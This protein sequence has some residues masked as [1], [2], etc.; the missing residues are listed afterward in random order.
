[1][2]TDVLPDGAPYNRQQFFCIVQ[3]LDGFKNLAAEI[4]NEHA[5]TVANLIFDSEVRETNPAE[6]YVLI[7]ADRLADY[8]ARIDQLLQAEFTQIVGTR[9]YVTS[10]LKTAMAGELRSIMVGLSEPESSD[11]MARQPLQSETQDDDIAKAANWVGSSMHGN[12]IDV[13]HDSLTRHILTK[14]RRLAL[15]QAPTDLLDQ[16]HTELAADAP[17]VRSPNSLTTYPSSIGGRFLLELVF[18]WTSNIIWPGPGEEIWQDVALFYFGAIATVQGYTDGNKR[19]ARM[20]Y[21]IT[22]L[23]AELPFVA[24]NLALQKALIRIGRSDHA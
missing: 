10:L 23:R 13:V 17:K 18:N 22:L 3:R 2:S 14:P 5:E 21:A 19:V 9:D 12:G 1:M 8:P 4:G 15:G 7:A 6:R 11:S 16:V 24:P 20:A